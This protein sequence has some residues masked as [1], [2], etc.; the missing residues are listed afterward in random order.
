MSSETFVLSLAAVYVG[1][2]LWAFKQL[3]HEGWQI[4]A[5]VPI[6]KDSTGRWHGLN[7]TYYGLLTANALLLAGALL[8]VLLGSLKVAT[9]VTLTLVLILLLICLPA[10]K[11]VA[12]LVEGKDYTFTVAGAFFVGI[13]VTPLA[14]RIFNIMLHQAGLYEVSVLPALAAF[15]IVSG[16]GEGLGRV[17]CISFGC[18][19]GKPLSQVHP[20]IQMVFNRWNFVFSGKMKKIAY[21]SGMDGTQV[22]PV[23]ALT[24]VLYVAVSLFSTL[25]FLKRHYVLAF[26]LTM[27][28]TQ[29]WRALSEVLRAD[30]RGWGKVSAYQVM[31]ILAIIYSV[32]LAVTLDSG[33]YVTT[34]L[35]SGINALWQP[36]VV[37]FLQ[38]LWVIVFV[39][40]GRS[41]VTGAEIS[42][43]LYEDRI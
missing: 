5:S 21:A 15:T 38:G 19:Y 16:F 32:V 23:Q 28:V 25:L 42:F 31:A 12:R 34:N 9:G 11:W 27:V 39:F 18:C 29:A 36:E 6:M 24:S 20:L 30:H 40:F 8:I 10:A 33:Q 2:A 35:P 43:H 17:A 13:F 22:V 4:L 26:V 37:V 3:P 14:L 41:M 1:F 7:F